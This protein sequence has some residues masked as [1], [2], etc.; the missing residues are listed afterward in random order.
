MKKRNLI[1]TL[2]EEDIHREDSMPIRILF[3]EQEEEEG[4]KE[5]R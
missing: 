3:R 4:E 5:V 1:L 2:K